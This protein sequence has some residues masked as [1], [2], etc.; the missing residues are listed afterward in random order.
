MCCRRRAGAFDSSRKTRNQQDRERAVFF[1]FGWV[2]ESKEVGRAL[3]CYCYRCQRIRAWEHWR[4]TEW[5][6]VFRHQDHPVSLEKLRPVHHLPRP[7]TAGCRPGKAGGKT[8]RNFPPSPLS[9]RNTSY[10]RKANCS[11]TSS[12]VPKSAAGIAA[13]GHG[14]R[15]AKDRAS[16]PDGGAPAP[17]GGALRGPAWQHGASGFYPR[18][19]RSSDIKSPILLSLPGPSPCRYSGRLISGNEL[20]LGSGYRPGFAVGP[21]P[22]VFAAVDHS[23]VIADRV[24]EPYGTLVL[25][26]AVTSS[27]WRAIVSLMLSGGAA[28]WPWPG[29]RCSP[30]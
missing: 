28:S 7:R 16:G 23:D 26:G 21:S 3:D 1:I 19:P 2:K 17:I 22:R 24:G 6:S 20:A 12:A 30:R 27:R 11:A 15:A 9:W 13:I 5:F 14:R 18:P 8:E 29:M 10:R 25:A 4:E